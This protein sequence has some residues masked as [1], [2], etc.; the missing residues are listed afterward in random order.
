MRQSLP[1]IAMASGVV[2]PCPM[3]LVELDEEAMQEVWRPLPDE[4]HSGR[5]QEGDSSAAIPRGCWR[6]PKVR[7]SSSSAPPSACDKVIGLDVLEV[8]RPLPLPFA[9]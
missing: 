2:C 8:S 3:I 7:S 5:R 9:R 4:D 6:G 1:A